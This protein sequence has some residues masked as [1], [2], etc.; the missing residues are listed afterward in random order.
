M[1]AKRAEMKAKCDADPQACEKR[2]AAHQA[3]MKQG[4]EVPVP[5]PVEPAS[6]AVTPPA[7]AKTT[8]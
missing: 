6:P 7:P 2:K 4:R 8:L 5:K 3:K 1:Q